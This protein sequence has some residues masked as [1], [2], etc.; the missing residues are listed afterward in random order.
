MRSDE[1]V[2][3]SVYASTETQQNRENKIGYQLYHTLIFY[4]AK[5]EHFE[6]PGYSFSPFL[7]GELG[8]ALI[9]RQLSRDTGLLCA[10]GYLTLNSPI[11]SITELGARVTRDKVEAFEDKERK[12]ADLKAAVGKALRSAYESEAHFLRLC[13]RAYLEDYAS[14]GIHGDKVRYA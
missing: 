6:F 9:S 2:L 13:Y 4:L 1:K 7:W 11:I 8:N 5:V 12:Y 10:R 3:L 14:F